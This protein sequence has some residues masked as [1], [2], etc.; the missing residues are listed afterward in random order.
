MIF[1]LHTRLGH[2]GSGQVYKGFVQDVG[3]AV[4]VKRIFAQSEQYEKIFTNEVKIISRIIHRYLVQFI[5]WCHEQGECLL[6]YAYM[7]NSSLDEHLF[8]CRTSL[9]WDFRYKIALGLASAIHYLHEDAEQW[10]L[11]RDI[12][13][14]N[15]LLDN[16]SNT[17]LGDFGIAKLMDS[18]FRTQTAG[19]VWTFGYMTPEYANGGRTSKESD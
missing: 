7:P 12:K 16:D 10:V 5:G 1:V 6:V 3:G 15:V 18:W 19:V 13:S 4:T 9:L 8:G 17:K 2:G 11:H 14:A